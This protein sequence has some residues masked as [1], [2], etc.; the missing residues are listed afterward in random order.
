MKLKTMKAREIQE[1]KQPNFK[2]EVE[3]F[4][5]LPTS[6]DYL[7]SDKGRVYSKKRRRFLSGWLDNGGYLRGWI[8]ENGE[9]KKRLFHILVMEAFVGRKPDKL[10]TNHKDGNKLNNRLANLEYCTKSENTKHSYDNGLQ[11]QP[12]GESRWNCKLSDLQIREIRAELKNP[13]MLQKN[14]A[15]KYNVS[16]PVISYI[17]HNPDYRKTI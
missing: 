10:D 13:T 8:C 15:I 6:P 3:Q 14:L 17:K 7:I 5:P 12:R 2:I 9:Q 4:K 11:K 1:Q 16:G